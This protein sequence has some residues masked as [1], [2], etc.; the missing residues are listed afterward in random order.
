MHYANPFSSILI[1]FNHLF[2]TLN[3]FLLFSLNR[4]VLLLWSR[5]NK[6]LQINSACKIKKHM[7][8]GSLRY[9]HLVH[10]TAP[11]GLHRREKIFNIWQQ[12]QKRPKTHSHSHLNIL[13]RTVQITAWELSL[14]NKKC[15]NDIFSV[16]LEC[17]WMWMFSVIVSTWISEN[18]DLI[19]KSKLNPTNVSLCLKNECF[20]QEYNR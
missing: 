7:V 13:T 1:I 8:E 16:M 11:L 3:I 17:C 18:L 5:G 19:P 4:L 6:L 15:T 20:F 14:G 2:L 9:R 12:T 10:K